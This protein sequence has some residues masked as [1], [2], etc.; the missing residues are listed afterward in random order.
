MKLKLNHIA[1]R[2]LRNNMTEAEKYIWYI[3]RS[4]NLNGHKFRRQQPI[5]KF[6]ADFVCFENKKVIEIDGGQHDAD[7]EKDLQRDKWLKGQGFKVLRFWNN[8]VMENREWVL[9]KIQEYCSPSPTPPIEGG[10]RAYDRSH[11]F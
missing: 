2:K 8:E 3:L 9:E 1:A 7:K 5:G 6:I 11:Y 4:K 10:E